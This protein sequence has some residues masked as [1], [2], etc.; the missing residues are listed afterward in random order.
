MRN[1]YTSYFKKIYDN[2]N[3]PYCKE[4]FYYKSE[5]SAGKSSRDCGCDVLYCDDEDHHQKILSQISSIFSK[6]LCGFAYFS[7]S[8]QRSLPNTGNK[9]I[10]RTVTTTHM[11]AKRIVF[12]AG[13]ILSSFP[14][15]RIKSSPHHKINI[16]E[17]SQAANTN[18]DIARSTNS[19]KSI[20]ASNIELVSAANTVE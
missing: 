6:I 8:N 15:E 18:N 12:I 1:G 20:W 5:K 4:Y 17:R 7:T 2:K 9:K 13:L 3:T 11:T 10:V 19:Q 16:I 14:P